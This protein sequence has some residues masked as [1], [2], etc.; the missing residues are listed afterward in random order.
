[1]TPPDANLIL[2]EGEELALLP[3]PISESMRNAVELIFGL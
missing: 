3:F 1:M 2:S